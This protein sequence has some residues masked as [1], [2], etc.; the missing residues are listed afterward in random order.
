MP[1]LSRW[2]V[3]AGFL[4]LLLALGLEALLLR[5]S[6]VLPAVPDAVLQLGAVHLLT[7]GWLL[8]VITGVA[9]WMFPRHPI[10]PPRG[11]EVPGWFAFGL[12]NA[13]LALRLAGEPWRLGYG[14]PAWPLAL[15]AA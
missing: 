11:N 9:F 12:L 4:C 2:F 15:S 5:P 10:A 14:G 7:V 6:G 13:G 3:K 8:Q 1:R